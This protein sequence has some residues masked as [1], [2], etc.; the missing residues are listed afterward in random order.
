VL[1]DKDIEYMK[2]ADADI[3]INR[4]VPI[5]IQWTTQV[6]G[7]VDPWTGEPTEVSE[8][9][10]TA[11][12]D[13]VVTEV[14]TEERQLESGIAVEEGDIIIDVRYEDLP[15][16]ADDIEKVMYDDEEY[17]IL[18]ADNRG[19]GTRVRV[20]MVGKLTNG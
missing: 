1:S 11:T 9:E 15:I 3:R 13:A 12:I 17:T 5:V 2:Q 20:E 10:V 8:K 6:S 18:G 7:D 19:I 4:T 16:Y 14:T